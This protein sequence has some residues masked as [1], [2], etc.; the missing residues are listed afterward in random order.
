MDI[1]IGLIGAK[2]AGKTTAYEVIQAELDVQE[3]TLAA[4]LKDVSALA[5]G[6]ARD[7][8]DSHRFKEVDLE[9]PIFLTPQILETIWTAYD[10]NV[11]SPDF[12]DKFIRPHVGKVLHTPRQIAQYVGTEV[13]RAWSA[14]IHCLEAAKAITKRVGVVTDMR[15]PNEY[16]F[17]KTHYPRFHTV[18][19]QNL[20]AEIRASSDT[21]ASEAYLKDLAKKADVTLINDSSIKDFQTKVR[22]YIK[23]TFG[24]EQA[25]LQRLIG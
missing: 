15:F 10:I 22:N 1:V 16:N 6:V 18:Y 3:I 2:G 5:T 24:A 19:I 13:L 21:H 20:G 17:F 11:K 12:F 9:D 7:H 23:E 14:D 8:F 4:K 25:S